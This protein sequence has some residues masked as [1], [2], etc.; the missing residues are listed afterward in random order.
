MATDP[1]I[2][3]DTP[4]DV[5]KAKWAK[6]K[7]AQKVKPPP[8]PKPPTC[9]GCVY[10]APHPAWSESSGQLACRRYPPTALANH[11]AFMTQYPVVKAGDWC[12]EWRSQMP[13]PPQP[14]NEEGV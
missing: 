13:S 1:A 9:E 10:V 7:V 8:P 14:Q 6:A 2:L 3:F 5:G 4:K 12:G 11:G